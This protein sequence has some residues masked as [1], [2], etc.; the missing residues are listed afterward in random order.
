[1]LRIRTVACEPSQPEFTRCLKYKVDPEFF[2]RVDCVEN[3]IKGYDYNEE[4][5]PA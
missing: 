4:I 3:N 1:M 2:C 5:T